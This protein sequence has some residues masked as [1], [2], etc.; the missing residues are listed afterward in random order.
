M[1]ISIFILVCGLILRYHG[2]DWLIGG[3]V[4]LAHLFGVSKLAIELP[5]IA[6]GTSIPKMVVSM[7]AAF[8]GSGG[9]A[10]G[11]IVPDNMG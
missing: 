8:G 6:F 10:I 2:A 7:S 9:L 3:S 1:V 11:N 4:G 5:V